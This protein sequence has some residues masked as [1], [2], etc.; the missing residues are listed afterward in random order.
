MLVRIFN[1]LTV[2]SDDVSSVYFYE[3]EEKGGMHK[4]YVSM[5]NGE[6]HV[7]EDKSIVEAKKTFMLVNRLLGLDFN[8][9]TSEDE[10][11]EQNNKQK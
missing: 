2:N 7:C 11:K 4:T 5:K 8:I 10:E 3:A 6:K 9:D 1:N